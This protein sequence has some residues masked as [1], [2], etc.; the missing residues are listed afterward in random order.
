MENKNKYLLYRA[1]RVIRGVMS[2][3][4]YSFFSISRTKTIIFNSACN[5]E[6]TWNAKSLFLNGMQRFH[7]LGY[8]TYFVIDNDKERLKL[9]KLYGDY[10]ITSKSKTDNKIILKSAVWVLST[11]ETPSSGVFL[12]RNRFV[13]HL[14]HGTPIK[15]IGLMERNV[16]TPKRIFYFLNKSNISVFLST[17]SFF[18]EYMS[19]AFG[20]KKERIVIAPQPRIDD[21]I[22]KRER[23]LIK[24][25]TGYKYILYAPTWRHYSDTKLFPFPDFDLDSFS[26]RLKAN[27]IIILLR[28]HPR[29]ENDSKPYLCDNIISFDSKKCPDVSDSLWEVDGLITDYSS[30]YCDYLIL[31]KPVAFIPYDRDLYEKEI[32]FSTDYDAITTDMKLKTVDDFFNF[33]SRFDSF[34]FEKYQSTLSGKINFCPDGVSA[35]EYNVRFIDG[36][37]KKRWLM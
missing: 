9:K 8:K 32:G 2:S 29:F 22:S 3:I 31:N 24:K 34:D 30:I 36:E 11:L 15:N 19:K 10:F 12:N 28:L 5:E 18:L 20:V 21:F 6:F 13:Y 23:G 26:E 1:V 27:K 4:Y 17:S 25:V 14:G 35:T 16:S 7:E 33:I 37:Y